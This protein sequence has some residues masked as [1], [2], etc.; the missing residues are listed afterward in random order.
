MELDSILAHFLRERRKYCCP[1]NQ[2]QD[3]E[4]DRPEFAS[5]IDGDAGVG[6]PALT[7]AVLDE[8]H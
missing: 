4:L 3:D 1:C 2:I 7:F 6:R 5:A 8:G